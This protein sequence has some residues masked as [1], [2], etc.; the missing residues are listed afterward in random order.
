MSI[1]KNNSEFGLRNWVNRE[2]HIHR[3]GVLVTNFWTVNFSD[4]YIYYQYRHFHDK[5]L[6]SNNCVV[7]SD[8][9]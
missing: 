9:L 2:Y 6:V 7:Q 4:V 8:N 5:S 1:V 3:K